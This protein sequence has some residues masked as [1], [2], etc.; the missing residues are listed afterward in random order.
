MAFFS[1]LLMTAGCGS[2]SQSARS[3]NSLASGSPS[4][5]E[6][7]EN[8]ILFEEEY[9]AQQRGEVPTYDIPVVR[10]AKVEQWI[11][12]FQGKGRKW[13][14]TWLE[15]S[16]KYVVMMK[17]ILREHDLPEDI[18]FL[19]MIESG[20]S[21]KAYSRARAVGL[22]QFMKG[23]GRLYGL[24]INYWV[25]ER[26]DPEKSTIAAARHLKDLYDQF[27]S[28]KLAAAASRKERSPNDGQ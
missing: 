25:D 8:P 18:V 27:Q 1:L 13:F 15:R 4:S 28:W 2:K 3:G 21:S 19:A 23:T 22:W 9:E 7:Q 11:E 6:V 17:K 20:F 14:Y 24:K 16:S 26:R 12:Y 5:E 10:N